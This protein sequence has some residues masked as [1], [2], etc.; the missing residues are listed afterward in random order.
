MIQLLPPA[1]TDW[2]TAIRTG[3]G[4][5]Q[6]VLGYPA[7]ALATKDAAGAL[8]TSTLPLQGKANQF[9]RFQVTIANTGAAAW[10]GSLRHR[11]ALM[12]D[13]GTETPRGRFQEGVIQRATPFPAKHA[14][15]LASSWLAPEATTTPPAL[16][17]MPLP[18]DLPAGES[19][20]FWAVLRL[21][22]IPGT[23]H[24]SLQPSQIQD[25][26]PVALPLAPVTQTIIVSP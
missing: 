26:K 16:Q 22:K 24:F 20:A 23:Y 8:E 6:T 10:P 14:V 3:T 12:L 18:R 13:F 19:M 25:G 4:R 9:L 5:V 21:P 1:A 15:G 17:F 11:R 7:K 2:S